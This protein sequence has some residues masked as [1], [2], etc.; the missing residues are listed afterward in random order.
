MLIHF[1]TLCKQLPPPP[2]KKKVRKKPFCLP[3]QWV[4]I[5]FLNFWSFSVHEH[6]INATYFMQK[7]PKIFCSNLLNMALFLLMGAF[8]LSEIGVLLFV[9]G[10]IFKSF[11]IKL[12]IHQQFSS[13]KREFNFYLLNPYFLYSR[14]S[15]CN[16]LAEFEVFLATQ[17]YL[18]QHI[19][20]LKPF[21]STIKA[22]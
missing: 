4:I 8:H 3:L 21:W 6:N 5:L 19:H 13:F 11:R 14:L 1:I 17:V 20:R 10:K 22:F 18:V 7:L 9:E 16:D 12:G 15:L 2:L